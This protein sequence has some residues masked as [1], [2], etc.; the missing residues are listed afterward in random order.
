MDI[1]LIILGAICLLVGFPSYFTH[2]PGPP[3]SYLG[4]ILL[5]FTDK[6]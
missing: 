3:L 2:P 1:L 4:L 5:H 6:I